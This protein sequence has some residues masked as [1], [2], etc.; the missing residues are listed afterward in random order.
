MFDNT[1][2]T[3]ITIGEGVK[4]GDATSS[5]F[6]CLGLDRALSIIRD[7]TV[8]LGIL[9]KIYAY[10]DDLTVLCASEHADQVSNIV[11]KALSQIGLQVNADKS[12][13]LSP[14]PVM[15]SIPQA[16][17]HKPFVVLGANLSPH[18][19]AKTEF[20]STLL[21][22]Q[23]N[24]FHSLKSLPLHPQVLFTILRICGF[25]RIA[26]Y[27]CASHPDDTGPLTQ[28]FD[29][30]IKRIIELIVDPSGR[31]TV[32]APLIHSVDGAAAPN[33]HF[34]RHLLWTSTKTMAITDD[35]QPPRLSLIS[36]HIT[37]TAGAQ[38]DTRWQ[39]YDAHSTMTP[40]Q[41]STALVIHLNVVPSH[42]SLR[43][44][45]CNCGHV[46][47]ADEETIEHVLTCDTSTSKTHTHRHDG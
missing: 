36:E 38:T 4:Q 27:C 14:S 34:N 5:L 23:Q 42:L 28:D 9:V 2:Q 37:T 24:Y 44:T 25:P 3:F 20:M 39:Y 35:P 32:G 47:N 1:S 8:A 41:F 17:L 30:T 15:C 7:A 16:P 22:K 45:K 19:Q 43:G 12:A 33:Y 40:A 31:T 46:Y 6:F 18:P 26:Y 29:S 13:I 11:I 21:S 10:M